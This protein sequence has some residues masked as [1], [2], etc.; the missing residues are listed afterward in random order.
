MFPVMEEIVTLQKMNYNELV[1]TIHF[2]WIFKANTFIC[3]DFFEFGDLAN[4]TMHVKEI[5]HEEWQFIAKEIIVAIQRV[6]SHNIFHRDIKLENFKINSKGL[7]KVCNFFYSCYKNLTYG[8]EP[9][10]NAVS[11]HNVRFI[12]ILF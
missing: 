4:Y 9:F 12:K 2:A 5:S 6:H 8:S 1:P 3:T 7:V 10:N 11:I